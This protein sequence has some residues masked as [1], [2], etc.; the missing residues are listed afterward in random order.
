MGKYLLVVFVFAFNVIG[1][2]GGGDTQDSDVNE[3]PTEQGSSSD[4]TGDSSDGD[5]SDSSNNDSNNDS[6]NDSNDDNSSEQVDTNSP[7]ILFIIS[8][9][10]GV[11]AS[12]QYPYSEDTPL[13]PE[14]NAIADS[15]IVYTNAWVTPACTT[16]RAAILTGKHGIN[17]GVTYV[18]G[19]LDTS[20][21][22]L[23]RLLNANA[24]TSHYQSAHFGKWHLG[25]GNPSVTHPNDSGIEYYAGNLSNVSDYYDWQL[26]TNGVVSQSTEYHST[27][28]TSLAIDWIDEQS[29][30][31]FVWLAY[32]APHSPLHLPP[33][34]LHTRDYLTGTESDIEGRK[35]EYYLAAIEAMDSEIGRL[36]NSLSAEQRENTIII[37]MGDNGTPRTVIDANVFAPNHG[38][39]TLYEGG[40]NVP[41]IVSGKGVERKNETDNSLINGTDLYATI[42][43]L[44]GAEI[45]SIYDSYSF[46][47]T[48]TS[49]A[50]NA[51]RV[52][53]YSEFESNNSTGWAVQQGDYKL[54][55]FADGTQQLFD[56][57][58]DF[59]EADDLLLTSFDSHDL[60]H[61]LED[62]AAQVRGETTI[63]GID[64][65][66][67]IFDKRSANCGDYVEQY[68]SSVLDV[69]NGTVFSGD[70]VITA[71]NG[72]CIFKTNAIPN[73][74][75][76]DGGRSFPNDVSAQNDTFEIT[77]SP[78][79]AAAITPI[80]LSMDNAI[81]LNGVKVDLLA[82]GCYGVGN[83]KVGCND[84]AQAWRYDPMSPSAG[85]LVDSHNAH[86][87]PD[88]TYHYH[89]TPNA[90][91]HAENNGIASP[92]VGFAAD[93]FPIYGPYFD[94]E[95]VIRKA[96]SSYR[97]ITG[98]RPTTNGSP[99]GSYDG[100]FRDDN[101]YVE[102]LGDLDECNGMTIDGVYGYYITDNY[103]YVVNC[104]KGTPDPT[105]NK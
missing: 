36:V 78:S 82:A 4:N 37:Y 86:A 92:V 60:V 12:A 79:F 3:T 1:C 24:N 74:D 29:A 44:A 93:G 55:E 48:L 57:E 77:S 54:I 80:S 16:T 89:G 99:G 87:Q 63:S 25:G 40:V 46:A 58:N 88:G 95:G 59:A 90:F 51:Q 19:T 15:G 50:N 91:Y 14:I 11:D 52:F 100:T 43:A 6:A 42:A 28:I 30:P 49:S 13:T 66:N 34:D 17:S 31:W 27:K 84:M 105:F 76:N 9:D 81:L 45:N 94:D 53:N 67:Q 39:G 41:L 71:N 5:S 73:H 61:A 97:L 68:L 102:G 104:F 38:K 22:T 72:K 18:P 26:T 8:D 32:S 83:G 56:V 101:E 85:F 103:P 7:N 33:A 47:D 10:Q 70:L 75:F 64:I 20:L 98:N 2:G 96:S 35:R 21:Q 23:P 62:I 69:N 65:T